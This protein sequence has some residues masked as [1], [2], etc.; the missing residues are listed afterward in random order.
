MT[1]GLSGNPPQLDGMAPNRPMSLIAGRAPAIGSPAITPFGSIRDVWSEEGARKEDVMPRRMLAS[2]FLTVLV[3]AFGSVGACGQDPGLGVVLGGFGA[4]AGGSGSSLDMG[5]SV[6]VPAAGGS[7]ASVSPSMT[8]GGLSFRPR[9]AAA[10]ETVRR[11]FVLDSTSGMSWIGGRRP[12]AME[13]G[14]LTGGMGLGGMPR[15]P[16][17]GGMGVMPPRIGY[18]FRQPPSLLT[19]AGGGM[20]M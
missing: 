8:G 19:Q 5:S 15:M 13:P 1:P 4:M 16:A 9:P 20:S 14:T 2:A 3:L 11:P 10:M 18:P 17:A 6:V 7:G 12:F